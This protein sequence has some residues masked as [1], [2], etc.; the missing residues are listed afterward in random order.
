MPRTIKTFH[1]Q[2]LCSRFVFGFGFWVP[3]SGFWFWVLGSR[4]YG[5]GEQIAS[6]CLY[7]GRAMPRSVMM[8]VTYFAGVTSNAGLRIFAPSGVNRADPTWVTSRT[9]RSSMGMPLPSGVSR[10]IVDSGAAT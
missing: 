5:G 4:S 3:G 1:F 8:A 2:V 6:D 10:S 7:G 9:F